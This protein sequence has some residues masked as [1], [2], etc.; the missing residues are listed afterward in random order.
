MDKGLDIVM[1]RA[2][3]ACHAAAYS[4]PKF[5]LSLLARPGDGEAGVRWLRTRG[6]EPDWQA[7]D[8]AGEWLA[9][10]GHHLLWLGQSQYPERLA[11]SA[12]PP[13]LLF[14]DGDP[15]SLAAPQ[16]AVVGSRQASPQGADI[17][18]DFAGKLATCGLVVTSGLARGIDGAAHR[19]ALAAGG[20]TVAVLGSAVD[21]IYPRQHRGLAE[22][23]RASGALVSEFPFGAVPLPANFPR[24]NRIISGLA[25]GT[26]VVEAALRSGSL[27]TALHALEQGRDVFAVPGSIHSP[28]TKGCHA[29]IK[30]GAKLVEEVTD[31]LEELSDVRVTR[32]SA[33]EIAAA[34]TD[35][36]KKLADPR[37]LRA[38]GWDP[39]TPDDIVSRSGL[40][41]QEVSSMLLKLELAGII[42][43]QGTGSFLRIR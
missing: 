4:N 18:F 29:L 6:L 17:A 11:A 9:A 14:V 28:L 34:A 5:P 42:Q 39:F 27:S 26:L 24:R 7:A 43:V 15:S 8:R 38:C 36:A 21:H 2:F 16:I 40:T 33:P 30:Q 3:L 32:A 22:E 20:K 19:G 25:V 23:I 41:V 37:L 1:L 31:I 35:A 12:A 13:M 10:P